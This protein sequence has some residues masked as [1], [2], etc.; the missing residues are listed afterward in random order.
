MTDMSEFQKVALAGK[1]ESD[2]NESGIQPLGSAVLIKLFE[3][4]QKGMI[5]L[6]YEVRER[7]QMG[8]QKAV[9]VEFGDEAKEHPITKHLKIGDAIVFAKY[10][11]YLI[12]G[13]DK[14]FYR[15]LNVKDIYLK[16]KSQ[17]KKEVTL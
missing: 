6:P 7:E 9:I 13:E 14:S 2:F 16:I 15:V 5:E 11:G 8:V 1:P 17:E 12:P 3:V 10:A 4:K